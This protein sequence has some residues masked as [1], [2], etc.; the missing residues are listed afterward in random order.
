MLRCPFNNFSK[1]DGSCPFSEDNFNS[2][3]LA[4]NGNMT[5]GRLMGTLNRL[6]DLKKDVARVNAALTAI[7]ERLDGLELEEAQGPEP[8]PAP[9]RP[10]TLEEWLLERGAE[11]FK[12]MRTKAAYRE[13]LADMRAGRVETLNGVPC[14]QRVLT[15]AV[16]RVCGL[17][18][19]GGGAHNTFHDPM[20]D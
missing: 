15:A 5:A 2:C 3:L 6:D 12:G 10:Q 8:A 20:G 11:H 16:M 14:T 1:C 18:C 7:I 4:T 17:Y 19:E 13:Y 9:P